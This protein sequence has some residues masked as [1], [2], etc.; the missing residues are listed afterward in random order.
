[1]SADSYHVVSL[2]ELDRI[3]VSG[4]DITWRPVRRRLGVTGVGINAVHRGHGENVVEK[5]DEERLGHEELYVVV[6]RARF[7]LDGESHTHPQDAR[8]SIRAGGRRHAV[9]EE[10]GTTVPRIGRKA[11]C[12]RDV[13]LG[14]LLRRVFPR[15][16]V[17]STAPSRR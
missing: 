9:A 1:M 2:D 14:V 11:R 17:T 8:V 6:S 15:R 7:E 5:H 16:T 4:A 13:R 12:A 10:L 3:P